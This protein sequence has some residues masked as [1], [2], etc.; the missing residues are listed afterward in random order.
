MTAGPA[1]ARTL[2][3]PAIGLA[4]A[5]GGPEGAIYE[6]GA[7]RALEEAIEG[8]DL[9]GLGVYVGVSAGAFI[10]ANLANRLTAAQMCRALIKTEPGEH[11][12]VPE[13]FFT[14]A[15]GEFVRGGLAVP[16]LLLEALADYLAHPGDRTLLESLT[17]LSRALPVGLFA[18]EPI[19][20]YLQKI[21]SIKGRTDDFRRLDQRL[22][23]VAADLE[24]GSAVRFGDV[25]H[26]HV[27]ISRAVQ[28]STALPG[29]YPPVE[30][31]GRHYVDGVL[32]KTLHA[33][34]ALEA[35]VELLLCVNPL[36]PINTDRVVTAGMAGA[37]QLV[38]RGLPTVLSQTFRTLIHS[39]LRVGMAAYAQ[40]YSGAEVV[41]I[42]PPSDDYLMFFTNVFSFSARRLV[43]N[44]AYQATRRELWRRREELTPLLA[45]HGLRL[46]GE[47]LADLRRDLWR[48]V[49][50]GLEPDR[51][52]SE[53]SGRLGHA[54]D[55]LE[56]VLRSRRQPEESTD[57]PAVGLTLETPG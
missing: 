47:E 24:S 10:A 25:E 9:N 51:R 6:I 2:A 48:G 8:L 46:R 50:L 54:L 52:A 14:P 49:G 37:D 19:R 12:F 44:H 53:L 35:G 57:V 21:Y 17:R 20:Q 13:T 29:L 55:R 42:E 34:V 39:R 18:N 30:I 23:V 32:L 5:G 4:L 36:V 31:D 33:S 11:P 27:P 43:A 45:R 3:H 1:R 56:A 40:R 7:L 38:G 22:V 16:R 28:A 41:L 15:F 26:D